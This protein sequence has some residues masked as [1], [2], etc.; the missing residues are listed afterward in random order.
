MGLKDNTQIINSQNAYLLNKE[1]ISQ[2][3]E[4]TQKKAL[5]LTLVVEGNLIN[6]ISEIENL[7]LLMQ[8]SVSKFPVSILWITDTKV[9]R[10]YKHIHPS[11]TFLT[12]VFYQK[13]FDKK[14]TDY[15]LKRIS[16]LKGSL[17]SKHILDRPLYLTGGFACTFH[18]FINSGDL[19]A[20]EY[21]KTSL[22]E[23]KT[24]IE[25]NSK[26]KN[27]L[28]T[29]EGL[30]FLNKTDLS[31]SE[32]ESIK[33][34]KDPTAQE[35]NLLRFLQKNVNNSVSRDEIAQI[36]W[37][38]SWNSKYSDWAIDKAI[39]RLRKNIISPNYKIITVKNLGYELIK[40]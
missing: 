8:K 40:L 5:A 28:I 17:L 12:N 32:F 36:I 13:N 15:C 10:N 20:S 7:F 29:K 4:I 39:S 33:L 18:Q 34:S 16:F 26:I 38:K 14:E 31:G 9:V 37:R 35:I 21:V 1:I 30:E 11:S 22:L 27:E 6:Y 23:I 2:T 25:L 19:L 24:E 3:K